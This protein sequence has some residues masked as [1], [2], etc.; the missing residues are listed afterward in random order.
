MNMLVYI[1]NRTCAECFIDATNLVKTGLELFLKQGDVLDVVKANK[2][3][4]MAGH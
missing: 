3:R 4:L 1:A 2:P